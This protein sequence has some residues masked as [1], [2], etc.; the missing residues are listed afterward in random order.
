M[1]EPARTWR[2]RDARAN[3][4]EL[5][6]KALSEGPQAVTRHG[7]RAVVVV[8]A[9]AWDRHNRRRGDLVDFFARSPLREE[10]VEIERVPDR[11][12]EIDL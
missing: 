4:S 2:V 9:E 10:G 1:A 5:V 12:R 3:F 6:D 8:S 11:P 7:K